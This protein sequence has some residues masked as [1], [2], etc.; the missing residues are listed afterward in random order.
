MFWKSK[1]LTGDPERAQGV[2]RNLGGEARINFPI[3]LG[4]NWEW[5]MR[6][7]DMNDLLAKK[8]QEINYLYQR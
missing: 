7:D 5:R 6:E 8:L 1:N 2:A 4:G 3:R